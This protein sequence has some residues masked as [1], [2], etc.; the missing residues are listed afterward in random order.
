M[1]FAS[2]VRRTQCY[3]FCAAFIFSHKHLRINKFELIYEFLSA[4]A[5]VVDSNAI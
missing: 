2:V 1:S 5:F 3:Y 4:A